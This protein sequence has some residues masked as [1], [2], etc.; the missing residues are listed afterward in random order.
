MMMF[1][2]TK[3]AFIHLADHQ[4]IAENGGAFS[5]CGDWVTT[6]D[7]KSTQVNCRRYLR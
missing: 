4:E 3:F 7:E 2:M 6:A 1:G 5:L